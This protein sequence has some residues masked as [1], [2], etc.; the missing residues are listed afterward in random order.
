MDSKYDLSISIVNTNNCALLRDCLRS[1]IENTHRITYEIIVI[2][3]ASTDGSLDMMKKEF[4]SVI[5]IC[6]SERNGY[7]YSHN[8]GIE[9]SSGEYVL[10]FNEDML[11]TDN[12]L[13]NYVDTI[14]NEHNVGVLG[15]KL[16]NPDG[17]LQ[18]SCFN[19][20][21]V[22]HE[23]YQA[24]FPRNI[25][26]PDSKF[27][28]KHYYWDHNE[29]KDVDVVMGCCMLIPKSI[30][31]EIGNFDTRFFVY[32]EEVDLCKRIKNSGYRIVFT[33]NACIIHY[34]GQTSKTMS[35]KMYL[36]MIES[37]FKYFEKHHGYM[38]L[39]AVKLSTAINASVRII[40]WTLFLIFRKNN[41]E[42]SKQNVKRYW[43]VLVLIFGFT[44]A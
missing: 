12:A 4:P 22:K 19:F 30:F 41:T 40:G 43:K 20:M 18:H 14:K 35:I 29:N 38:S 2:D 39:M 27:R 26:L 7:G 32:A 11:L 34:G 24:I 8:K 6:N 17:T 16:L 9:A 31:K 15:C 44:K 13:D 23:Y 5:I 3:N 25:V 36:V 42:E 1:I 33:P 21:S 10:I 28:E 37:K